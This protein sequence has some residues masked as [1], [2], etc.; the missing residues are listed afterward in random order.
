MTA[1]APTPLS[2]PDAHSTGPAEPYKFLDFFEEEDQDTFAGRERDIQECL[3]RIVTSRLFVLYARSGFGK[4]S[5]LKAGLF[6]RLRERGLRPVYA[7]ILQDPVG[8]IR[9]AIAAEA[10]LTA[11]SDADAGSTVGR[12]SLAQLIRRLPSTGRLVL[13][14]DQFEEF[15]IRFRDRREARRV[16]LE[17]LHDLIAD[18]ALDIHLVFSLREDYLAE[19]EDKDFE[20]ALPHLFDQAYRVPPLTPF[21]AREAITRPLDQ[22]GIPYSPTLVSRMVDQLDE[23][24]LDP[25]LLQI[26]CTEVYRQ[27]VRRDA[28]HTTLTDEDVRR[29][30]GLDG[31]FR[32]YLDAVT[33][34]SVLQADPLLT[35]SVLDALLT[36]E[37]T[38]RAATLAE[39]TSSRFL[40]KEAEIDPILR[41]LVSRYVL[42]RSVRDGTEWFELIHER[43][44]PFVKQW[45]DQDP[46][47]LRFRLARDLIT[48]ANRGEYWRE[49]PDLLLNIGQVERVI[50]PF[51]ARLQLGATE[52]EFV[53]LSALIC[54]SD[55][56]GYWA[57]RFGRDL[58][59]IAYERLWKAQAGTIR[60]HAFYGAVAG[61]IA[62]LVW[63]LSVGYAYLLFTDFLRTD[64]PSSA[65]PT[66]RFLLVLTSIGAGIVGYFTSA[67]DAQG[68]LIAGRRFQPLRLARSRV[69]VAPFAYVILLVADQWTKALFAGPPGSS[70][71]LVMGAQE[72]FLIYLLL[73]TV[74]S[75][76]SPAWNRSLRVGAGAL[77]ALGLGWLS[78]SGVN[79]L[80]Q[81]VA[82][83]GE[84]AK[85]ALHFPLFLGT[86]GLGLAL[87]EAMIC[88]TQ[89]CVAASR[90]IGRAALSM[91]IWVA[92]A[93]LAL[94]L[95]LLAVMNLGL[96]AETQRW[97]GTTE[98][99][100][101]ALSYLIA[102]SVP[103]W[104]YYWRV[105]P[106][107]LMR[108]ELDGRPSVAA[109][110]VCLVAAGLAPLAFHLI[111]GFGTFPWLA[112][113]YDLT[114]LG[115]HDVQLKT[116]PAA[117]DVSY[118]RLSTREPVTWLST[119]E[120]VTLLVTD[121]TGPITELQLRRVD[122]SYVGNA[123]TKLQKDVWYLFPQGEYH[124]R[125]ARP[126]IKDWEWTRPPGAA[127]RPRSPRPSAAERPQSP[128]AIETVHLE[129][130]RR[131]VPSAEQ[132]VMPSLGRVLCAVV[133]KRDQTGQWVGRLSGNSPAD[134][135][136]SSRPLVILTGLASGPFS[137]TNLRITGADATG[138]RDGPEPDSNR[139]SADRPAT[140]T[141][142]NPPGQLQRPTSVNPSISIPRSDQRAS[143]WP[144]A[145]AVWI[146][147]KLGPN[148]EWSVTLTASRDA[149]VSNAAQEG[150]APVT[151]YATVESFKQADVRAFFP[152]VPV[153][154]GPGSVSN[155][156][157]KARSKTRLLQESTK[158][159]A[160]GWDEVVKYYRQALQ[161]G[162]DDDSFHLELARALKELGDLG[163]AIDVAREVRQ[164]HPGVAKHANT[165]AWYL[166][167]AGRFSEA[168]LLAQEA[169][170]LQPR[171]WAYQDT[172]AHAAYGSG[173]W[174]EAVAAWDKV[175][176][177]HPRY[178]DD[179]ANHVNCIEDGD[180]YADARRRAT[181][182]PNVDLP[183]E[184]F[185][186][187]P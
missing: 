26:F 63:S 94:P 121:A 169:T 120:P 123:D 109:R 44:V 78:F 60:D 34:D 114:T 136:D 85:I 119:R 137:T 140:V 27:A 118:A 80:M 99:F 116:G 171:D 53:F 151:L 165:L 185:A 86:L 124:L 131:A 18:P 59:M 104:W 156:V 92:L 29:V 73:L 157:E 95:L 66:S 135:R 144:G 153:P 30:G 22:R 48:N 159:N 152:A 52:T 28:E 33:Q 14:L 147:P 161:A 134:P 17:T 64:N 5:L 98:T 117:P 149:S 61:L 148:G 107:P 180:H 75:L 36:Y 112:R 97:A 89:A 55:E 168:L 3:E 72:F 10:G 172:L 103:A 87:A 175:L 129:L 91:L 102:V 68:T 179:T 145:G 58:S 158:Q 7:R 8:D 16:F 4:T 32:R 182:R 65:S 74:L 183:R 146:L 49:R 1:L 101:L 181:A 96:V 173:R 111:W 35:R 100:A 170:K 122:Y 110:G 62:G 51:R 93:S 84:T 167:L 127:V 70:T 77:F 133:L 128:T 154:P 20:E 105:A 184:V 57:D 11:E 47:F 82:R 25:P 90:S 81:F 2:R 40:A 9:A 67:V 178:F 162:D 155:L 21:G 108:P 143:S 174:G 163:A 38:K 37:G 187:L 83:L 115:R 176:A 24:D 125:M 132:I 142:L 160:R 15:F 39:L 138:G 106:L 71:W 166:C 56:A 177:A 43:L 19:L 46:E 23:V 186:P 79:D 113:A 76:S 130:E 69:L 13:V 50:Q 31:I 12:E 164:R 141:P 88:L 41:V 54:R 139:F 6:P 150:V 126:E 42:R 45:L